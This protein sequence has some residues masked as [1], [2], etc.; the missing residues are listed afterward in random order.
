MNRIAG[1]VLIPSAHS[2]AALTAARS[3]GRHDCDVYVGCATPHCLAGASRWV[4]RELRHEDPARR[5]REFAK[6]VGDL[7][8]EWRIETVLPADDVATE[9]LLAHR[10]LLDETFLLAPSRECISKAHDKIAL[11]ELA[12]S[13]HV[14][15]PRGVVGSFDSALD[16][17]IESLG[18]P[19]VVKPRRSR[20]LIDG[21]WHGAG[22]KFADSPQHLAEILRAERLVLEQGFLVQEKVDGEGRGVF[23]FAD[24][25]EVLCHF[26]HRR[27]REK[28]P[29]GGVST[30]CESAVAEPE[31]LDSA[32]SLVRALRWTGVAMVE[33]KWNPAS[34]EHWLMEINGRF[35]GSM[36]LAVA[37]GIDFPWL[38]YERVVRGRATPEVPP[39][40]PT[41]LWW[42][43]GDLDHFALRLRRS[44][45]RSLP[46][47]V[48]E[49]FATRGGQRL[50][51]DTLKWNDAR[52]FLFEVRKRFRP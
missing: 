31:L 49:M 10:E 51:A 22:V 26:A 4:R 9:S 15:V 44:G 38:W 3:L 21:R 17:R 50:D 2:R 42:I 23:V 5:P 35:W 29:W 34:R 13:R 46:Y 12:A 25:G 43:L 20:Y 8:R 18:Y 28:P 14:P 33:F 6:T 48:A 36:Q 37:S 47:L 39:P 41:R 19:V 27:I 16:A 24:D 11:A 30:L 40:T 32:C 7:A 52:P 1:S 45:L